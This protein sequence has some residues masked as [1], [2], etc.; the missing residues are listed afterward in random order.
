MSPETWIPLLATAI[1]GIATLAVIPIIKAL[2]ELKKGQ[3]EIHKVV[4]SNFSA[5]T[6][7]LKAA[8][9]KIEAL[10]AKS[11]A[12][13]ARVADLLVVL[14]REPHQNNPSNTVQTIPVTVV[15]PDPV[16]VD[17]VKEKK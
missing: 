17:V 14:N 1:I 8:N 11:T 13:D 15:N 7:E 16:K 9:E 5:Q 6:A 4:N 10:L 2:G 12:S 3:D